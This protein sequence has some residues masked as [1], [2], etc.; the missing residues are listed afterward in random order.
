MAPFDNPSTAKLTTKISPVFTDTMPEFV[1]SEHPIFVDFL[2]AYYEFLESAELQLT[3]TIDNVLLETFSAASLLDEDGNE[4]VLENANGTTGKFTVGETIT[5]ATSNATATI[6]ADDLGNE[7]KPRI[8][9][10]SSQQFITG[11]TIT[12]AT[13]SSTGVIV[14]YR[15]NPIQNIQQ[16]LEYANVDNTIYDFLDN[17]RDAFMTSLPDDLADGLDK[18]NIIKNIKDLYSIKGTS[19]GHKLFMK[20]LLN[21][22]VD[23]RYPNEYIIRASDGSWSS[24]KTLRTIAGPNSLAT[25]TIGQT[26]TGLTS[27]ATAIVASA[28][29]V[30]ELG[31]EI[32]EIE[33]D[34]DTIVGTFQDDETVTAI[35]NTT[36]LLLTFT[37]KDVL[38][39]VSITDNKRGSLYSVGDQ[40]DFENRGNNKATAE[41]SELGTGTISDIYVD[42]GGTDYKVGDRIIFT[43]GD[44]EVSTESA[45]GVV[46]IVDGAMLLDG[47][48]GDSTD[49]GDFIV[50]EDGTSTHLKPFGVQLEDSVA[51]VEPFSVFGTDILR[52]DTKGYYYPL[53]L[54]FKEA[55]RANDGSPAGVAHKHTFEEYK[56]QEFFMPSN[57]SNHA[58]ST[59]VTSLTIDSVTETITLFGTRLLLNRTDTSGVSGTGDSATG[60]LDDRSLMLMDDSI[61]LDEYKTDGDRIAIE[62]GTDTQNEAISR[63]VVLRSGGGYKKLP[64]ATVSSE[65]GSSAQVYGITND[66]GSIEDI[67]LRNSGFDYGIIPDV[68]ARANFQIKNVTGDFKIGEALTSHTGT[69]RS[70]DATRQ[71]LQVSLE[72]VV[73]TKLETTDAIP[74]ELEDTDSNGDAIS[75]IDKTQKSIL[76]VDGHLPTGEALITEDGDYIVTDA[77]SVTEF[78]IK[79][80]DDLTLRQEGTKVEV[81]AN[82]ILDATDTSGGDINEKI[83]FEGSDD[84]FL[85]AEHDITP[86]FLVANGSDS[87]GTNAGENL[88]SE[89]T[90]GSNV[91]GDKF[92][93]ENFLS[94]VPDTSAEG[95]HFLLENSDGAVHGVG[96]RIVTDASEVIDENGSSI[97]LV[98]N[99]TDSTGS[100]AGGSMLSE[101][102]SGSIDIL[103]EDI[104][105]SVQGRLLQEITPQDGAIALNGVDASST[106]AGDNSIHE[107]VGIDFSEG[108]TIISTI[109]G[110]ATIVNTNIAKTNAT[111][112]TLVSANSDYD[113]FLSHIGHDLIRLQDSF[114]YQQFSYEVVTAYGSDEWLNALRKSVHPAG[115]AVFGKI[116]ISSTLNVKPGTIGASLGGGVAHPT[117]A[118][119]ITSIVDVFDSVQIMS[120]QVVDYAAGDLTVN[121]TLEESPDNY[122]EDDGIILDGTDSDGSNSGESLLGETLIYSPR[123]VQNMELE[124]ATTDGL[125]GVLVLNGKDS[126]STGEGYRL[127][128]EGAVNVSFNL[129]LDSTTRATE[130][131]NGDMLLDGT[132][133]SG[134]NAGDSFELE[135]SLQEVRRFKFETVPAEQKSLLLEEGAG[136]MQLETSG[137]GGVDETTVRRVI[138]FASTQIRL[139]IVNGMT[140]GGIETI[141]QS[142]FEENGI[143]LEDGV[144]TILLDGYAFN[145]PLYRNLNNVILYSSQTGSETYGANF[146]DSNVKMLLEEKT[147]T[148]EKTSPIISDFNSYSTD[149]LVLNGSNGSSANAG[150]NMLL[151]DATI[152]P[153]NSSSE[154]RLVSEDKFNF[155]YS[156]GDILRTDLLILNE[157]ANEV[158]TDDE[159]MGILFEDSE[160]TGSF[161]LEDETTNASSFGG[162][163][164]VEGGTPPHNT[165]TKFLLET[166][167]IELEAE[168]QKGTVSLQNRSSDGK[169]F[170]RPTMINVREAGFMEL[171]DA[172][173]GSRLNMNGTD[174][175]S[176]D[177]GDKFLIEDGT[178]QSFLLNV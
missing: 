144:G 57:F 77:E 76:V 121:I 133:T 69:V 156:I 151:E 178:E 18:R 163:L 21:D 68:T 32:T 102:D 126:N 98:L 50:F 110:S 33:L 148:Q 103:L 94:E 79:L 31:I 53:Y 171:E 20:M 177:A 73:R 164:I 26:V 30:T 39:S 66:I 113:T 132:D 162:Y 70:Y 72:D 28:D 1:V 42:G 65:F 99:G 142:L 83:V 93:A 155:G 140:T 176:T 5:G 119:V 15:A 16:L 49:T 129:V 109:S 114:F 111:I 95:E 85:V 89:R 141:S 130:N 10:T 71:I 44:D 81:V 172:S 116:Q 100:N 134:S 167:R 161:R 90:G 56:N 135:D 127:L 35:S 166:T 48:D 147:A 136:K 13:S 159:I 138:S 91:F 115:F 23:I 143:L 64:T 61:E 60:G 29:I 40:F 11:E 107:L 92:I 149:F 150:E 52:S 47:S 122:A 123:S 88:V 46:S 154:N 173:S 59:N 117:A 78:N 170:A 38:N 125:G 74:M 86:Q 14:K 82:I 43:T 101:T 22:D 80:E 157:H 174:T 51:G 146:V 160:D 2:K 175:N 7:T 112:G 3:V 145:A 41:I 19:E 67:N 17:M 12:G 104:A 108:E 106:H 137:T 139:P 96:Q 158:S 75:G 87:D 36:D 168:N 120:H 165:N 169:R 24:K 6:L 34:A 131:E 4:I 152:F 84:T 153:G 37:V 27:G 97:K 63:A 62:F 55:Q 54:T 118:S 25:E 58:K 105:G 8:F 9:I 128:I 45:R 124:D